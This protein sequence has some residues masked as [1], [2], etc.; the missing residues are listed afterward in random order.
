MTLQPAPSAPAPTAVEL[1]TLDGC[2]LV[3][4]RY[5]A[6]AYNGEGGGG[7]SELSR[8]HEGDR[9]PLRFEPSGLRIPPLDRRRARFLGLPLPPGVAVTIEPVRLEGWL[10]RSTG[11][12]QL[13]FQSRFQLRLG[14]RYRAPDLW[15]DTQLST[16][17]V[18]GRRH[19]ACGQPLAADGTAVLVGV[20][21]VASSGETWLDRFLGLP[22]EALAVLRCQVR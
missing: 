22:D 9:Q 21:G 10:N 16:E 1:L 11:H 20:A 6:F 17:A 4:G 3:I 2:R 15:I 12:L 18:V 13:H 14:P 19:R 5:P 7:R 8:S